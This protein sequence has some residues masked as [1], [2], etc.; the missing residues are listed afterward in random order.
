MG[1]KK[2]VKTIRLPTP[3]GER[4]E[5]LAEERDMTE[6]D[7]Y[8]HLIRQ[9]LRVETG[10]ESDSSGTGGDWTTTVGSSITVISA[11]VLYLA[12]VATAAAT[13]S[14]GTTFGLIW[15]LPA[16]LSAVCFILSALL[17]GAYILAVLTV[18]TGQRTD[19][20]DATPQGAGR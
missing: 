2:A 8:R 16:S 6:A 7:M 18:L 3:E 1:D 11:V 4:I 15:L 14:I 12:G 9:G 19:G 17:M 20:P 13:A 10:D 5:E